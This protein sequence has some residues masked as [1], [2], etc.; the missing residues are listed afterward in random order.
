MCLGNIESQKK[1]K[2]KGGGLTDGAFGNGF[3]FK[4]LGRFGGCK[5]GSHGERDIYLWLEEHI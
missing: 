4:G 3:E 5:H 1:K 2:K